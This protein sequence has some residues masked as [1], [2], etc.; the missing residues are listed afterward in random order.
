[1]MKFQFRNDVSFI[2]IEFIVSN[3]WTCLERG[4]GEKEIANHGWSRVQSFSQE[5]E[6]QGQLGSRSDQ[7]EPKLHS[8]NQLQDA[9]DS[10]TQLPIFFLSQESQHSNR[11]SVLGR[12]YELSETSLTNHS[13]NRK[14]RFDLDEVFL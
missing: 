1:M 4:E 12:F 8:K 10:P 6:A 11:P 7:I 3:T 5:T 9:Y 2:S 14:V 13:E